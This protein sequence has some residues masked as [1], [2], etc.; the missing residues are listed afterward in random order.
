MGQKARN[1]LEREKMQ[2]QL[3]IHLLDMLK[4]TGAAYVK[5]GL[6]AVIVSLIIVHLLD[7]HRLKVLSADDAGKLKSIIMASGVINEAAKLI[8]EIGIGVK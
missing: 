8:P 5:T 4:E 3:L 1:R 7:E 6:G 2:T